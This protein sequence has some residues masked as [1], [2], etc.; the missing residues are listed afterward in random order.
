MEASPFTVK[1]PD[2]ILYKLF[3]IQIMCVMHSADCSFD[4]KQTIVITNSDSRNTHNLSTY[5]FH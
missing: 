3:W 5:T 2:H 4:L 1:W